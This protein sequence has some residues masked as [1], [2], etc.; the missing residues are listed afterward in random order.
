MSIISTNPTTT[1]STKM[2]TTPTLI[3]T[4]TIF[5]P[6]IHTTKPGKLFQT[7]RLQSISKNSVTKVNYVY[8]SEYH[9]I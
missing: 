9:T 7:Q 1:R 6:R 8:V 2:L 3:Y 4:N 5:K